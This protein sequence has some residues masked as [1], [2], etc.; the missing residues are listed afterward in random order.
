MPPGKNYT[1]LNFFFPQKENSFSHHNSHHVKDIEEDVSDIISNNSRPESLIKAIH[2]YIIGVACGLFNN[3]DDEENKNR[4]MIIHPHN[5]TKA[6]VKFLEF[7]KGILDDLK[8]GLSADKRD[9]AHKE[10]LELLKK[11]FFDFKKTIP[12][13]IFQNL[14]KNL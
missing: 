9:S 10:T 3:E 7:T 4:S 13:K 11:S 6:H 14:M 5:E 2:I 1:G 8:F 12:L